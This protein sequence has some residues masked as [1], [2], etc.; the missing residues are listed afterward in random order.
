MNKPISRR[1]F[2][3]GSLAVVGGL[4]GLQPARGAST[5]PAAAGT[6]AIGTTATG[7]TATGTTA[8][9]P[10]GVLHAYDTIPLAG[11]G[12]QPSRLA[13]G[14]GTRAGKEQRDIGIDG[15][16]KL[17][18]HA[19]DQGVRWWDTADMYRI[20]E[21]LR[22]ALKQFDR[23][24]VVITSKTSSKDA[25]GVE[26]DI[27]R[28]LK[29][30]DAE[31]IDIVLLHCMTDG[32]WPNK[33]RGAMDALSEAKEKGRVRAVGCSCHTFAALKA[34]CDE[35]WVEVDLARI[36]PFGKIM[37]LEGPAHVPEVV[38]VLETMRRRGKAVYGMKILGEGAFEGDEIDRSLRFALRQRYLSGFT[39]GFSSPK[40][41]DDIIRRVDRLAVK[42]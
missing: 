4:A 9:R 27:E 7:T 39:I 5:R 6:T 13:M 26:A 8:T 14:T 33:L 12:I 24:E 22:P 42:A 32:D 28:F 34:A 11:T 17:M 16:V 2:I 23:D 1:D 18:R 37:D 35:P 36:N 20:H 10:T 15:V 19:F 31:Y 41:V 38:E 21:Y 30:L 25:A 3:G 40:Q 29:E